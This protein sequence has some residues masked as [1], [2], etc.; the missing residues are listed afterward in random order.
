MFLKLKRTNNI[1]EDKSYL[2]TLV[3]NLE[4]Y[5]QR[6]NTISFLI[7]QA[8]QKGFIVKV[9]GLFAYIPF[10]YMPWQYKR[11]ES[12][13]IVSNTLIDKKF[14]CK[15]KAIEKDPIKI[16]INAKIH[17]CKELVYHQKTAVLGLVIGRTKFGI[18]VE[19]GAFYHWE[20]G[21]CIGLLHRNNMADQDFFNSVRV[22]NE[23]STFFHGFSRNHQIILGDASIDKVWSTGELDTLINTIQPVTIVISEHGNRSFFVKGKYEAILPISKLFY[24]NTSI[25]KI[26]SALKQYK[27]NDTIR[28]KILKIDYSAR[29]MIVQWLTTIEHTISPANANQLLHLVDGKTAKKMQALL[30]QKPIEVKVFKKS[31]YSKAEE[32][33]YYIHNNLEVALSITST[34]YNLTKKGIEAIENK[35]KHGD[36][37]NC[38]LVSFDDPIK[39]IFDI[40]SMST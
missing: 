28:C 19:I 12:W 27:N 16:E 21:S 13:R 31:K 33:K 9:G 2:K 14:Y 37:L 6:N 36:K 23:I 18:F 32:N 30:Y 10:H 8:K 5:Y 4:L 20:Y 24:P 15:V 3:S 1:C 7:T 40:D 11:I 17:I 22:G 39:V 38:T 25:S 35:F 29:K 26:K 34:K